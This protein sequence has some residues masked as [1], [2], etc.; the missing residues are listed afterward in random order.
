VKIFVFVTLGATLS[1][2]AYEASFQ[3]CDVRCAADRGCPDGLT[4]GAEGL[5]R[6][7]EGTT[8]TCAGVLGTLPSCVGLAA[9]C[10]P[11]ASDDCCST[12]SPIPGGTFYRSYDVAADG[13]YSNMNYPGTVSPFVLDKYEITVG[14]FRTFM[15][16]GTS[17]Q[18]DPPL[19]GA[20]ARVLN[21]APDQGGWDATW[22]AELE[23]D[24]STLVASV[25][26]DPTHQ[27]WT[28]APGANENLPMNCI[29]WYEALA[30]CA[31]DDGFLPTET[32]WNFAASGGSE[33]RSYPWS[34]PAGSIAIDCS[35][36][37]YNDGTYCVNSP[38]GGA[39]RVGS[40]SPEGDGAWGQADLA[41][42][43]F[44]WTLDE[45]A[46]TYQ[47]PC[48]DCANLTAASSVVLRGG[49]WDNFATD[50]RADYRLDRPP[51]LRHRSVGVR[52][53]R[54]SN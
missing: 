3:D 18:A 41:G 46:A 26:C 37:N 50:V 1:A 29:T 48:D 31:W 25:K 36:A 13:M 7:S 21:G 30:F 16:A 32:E 42:N 49:G 28:D 51:A 47:D 52:C 40:E 27:T 54:P 17:T 10:G 22:D 45:Y 39:N 33:Q 5:C 9:T 11:T 44:E 15:T 23:P 2:C 8:E 14:R 43:V 4:C 6:S 53:A 19:A 24:A 12:A 34:S 20:G 35:Y 38:N